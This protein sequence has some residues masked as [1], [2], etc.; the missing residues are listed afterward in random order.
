[1]LGSARVRKSL[2]ACTAR[3]SR[4]S[5]GRVRSGTDTDAMAVAAGRL[6][7]LMGTSLTE[8]HLVRALHVIP[9]GIVVANDRGTV[10]FRNQAASR[11]FGAPDTDAPV[12]AAVCEL[13]SL[14]VAGT[15]E[16]RTLDLYGP[17]R[18]A[19]RLRSV[20]LGDDQRQPGAFVV[21][22]DVS[23]R[24]RLESARR[25]VVASIGLALTVDSE[26]PSP[27]ALRMQHEA[28]QAA[29]T[30]DDLWERHRIKA[31]EL[32]SRDVVAVRVIVEEAVIR[33]SPAAQ[34]RR[35]EIRVLAQPRW[36]TVI[37]DR[38]QLVS[39]VANLLDNAVKYSGHNSS[40]EVVV[41]MADAMV[42]ISVVDQGVGI[43]ARDQGRIFERFYRADRASESHTRGTGLGLA[44]VRHVVSNHQGT[45]RVWSREGEGSTF[46]M[47][48]PVGPGPLAVDRSEGAPDEADERAG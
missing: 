19:L 7:A 8:D 42:E 29:R 44:I 9:Q 34:L 38:R 18:R 46:T 6:E 27:L 45:V 37:G 41:R 20:P 24:Q 26:I 16:S 31:G 13:I 2:G 39:G 28:F 30:I 17:P 3:V 22:D 32:P 5:R 48:L 4:I 35:I 10:L 47:C 36:L 12:E 21:L 25:D 15:S 40:V 1:M 23:E 11:Y 43:P 14:A 33:T